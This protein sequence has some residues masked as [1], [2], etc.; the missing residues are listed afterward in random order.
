MPLV[1]DAGESSRTSSFPSHQMRLPLACLLGMITGAAPG[2]SACGD[3]TPDQTNWQDDVHN[4]IYVEV[5]SS[6]CGFATTPNYFTSLG[7]DSLH[8]RTT[9]SGE[10]YHPTPTGFRIYIHRG[11]GIDAAQAKQMKWHINWIGAGNV[12]K[13][14]SWNK[15]CAGKSDRSKWVRD[16]ARPLGIYVDVDTSHC[17]Y[18]STP[19]YVTSM[20]G[21]EHW[22]I[23]GTSEIYSPTPKGFRMYIQS[24]FDLQMTPQW[25][26]ERHLKVNWF[27]L[28]DT[29]YADPCSGRTVPY[30][31]NWESYFTEGIYVDIHIDTLRCGFAATPQY[32]STMGGV[33]NL[34]LVEGSTQI[35]Y[36]SHF[37][38]R[39]YINKAGI[40]PALANSWGWHMQWMTL[41]GSGCESFQSPTMIHI[42][43]V[44]PYLFI[45]ML[46]YA[47]N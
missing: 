41:K 43:V 7:G 15:L 25:A 46:T 14:V 22:T 4:S 5:D 12:T 30:A 21:M 16:A 47:H 27:A 8:L 6:K 33:S 36:E 1:S 2:E 24:A 31:T 26:R 13:N 44:F 28:G 37:G 23:R 29:G 32:I 18:N 35:Y 17:G 3:R 11:D 20:S 38:F 42:F 39:T 19:T 45:K 34:S 10:V 40:T 9:G